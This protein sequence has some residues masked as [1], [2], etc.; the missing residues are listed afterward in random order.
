M[1]E[2]LT[3]ERMTQALSFFEEEIQSLVRAPA[4]NGCPMTSE[5]DRYLIHC[6]TARAALLAVGARKEGHHDDPGR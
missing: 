2:P 1:N 5:W 4:L 3:Q 6:E